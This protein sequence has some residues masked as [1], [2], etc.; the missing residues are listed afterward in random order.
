MPVAGPV[1]PPGNG[2]PAMT[3]PETRLI[4]SDRDGFEAVVR[5]PCHV[6]RFLD[7]EV[8]RTDIEHMVGL[9]TCAASAC[10]SQAWRFIAIQD[11]ELVAAMQAAVLERFEEL[12]LRPGLA[13]QEH[14]RMV[15]RQQALMFAKAPLC[16][17]VLA[18]P[19]ASPMEELMELAGITQGGARSP[20]CAPR[21]AERRGRGA[22]ALD[23]GPRHGLRRLLDVRADRGRRAARGA[24]RRRAAGP[25]GRARAHRPPGGAPGGPQAAA[26]GEGAELPLGAGPSPT[27]SESARPTRGGT[28]SGRG[29]RSREGAPAPAVAGG[30]T[31]GL[32]CSCR[33]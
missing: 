4:D 16:I 23:L 1:P 13:L 7:D 31:C 20:V 12:A 17:A 22:A 6:R 29:R 33:S 3:P 18:L 28:S 5:D 19:T 24:P 25:A 14:K 30:D 11:R 32:T 9:A 8:P 26:V 15:A 2:G 10:D 27:G 21:A